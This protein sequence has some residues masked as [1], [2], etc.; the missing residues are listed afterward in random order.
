MWRVISLEHWHNNSDQGLNDSF[1]PQKNQVLAV[2][3]LSTKLLLKV[4]LVEALNDA[5]KS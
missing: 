5:D 4:V 2:G 3:V 1:L